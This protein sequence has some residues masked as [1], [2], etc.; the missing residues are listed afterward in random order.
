[1]PWHICESLGIQGKSNRDSNPW[2][3]AGSPLEEAEFTEIVSPSESLPELGGERGSGL[4]SLHLGFGTA[5]RATA[6]PA[7]LGKGT[8]DGFELWALHG[9]R[10][11]PGWGMRTEIPNSCYSW[12]QSSRDCFWSSFGISD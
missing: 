12:L 6:K 5:G 2:K 4:G 9:L 11:S 1:M 7:E 3:I 10:D 8:K